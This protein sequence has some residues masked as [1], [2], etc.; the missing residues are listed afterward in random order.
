MGRFETHRV[1]FLGRLS[2]QKGVDR[3]GE[4]ADRVRNSGFTAD[5]VAYRDGPER[6]HLGR[7]RIASLGALGW[8]KRDTAFRGVSA[9]LVP[10]RENGW[11]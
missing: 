1:F 2:C 10:S 8:D 5:F 7:H 6:W 4:V 3:F 9:L 11:P